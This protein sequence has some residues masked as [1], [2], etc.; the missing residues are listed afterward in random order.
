[1]RPTCSIGAAIPSRTAL[2]RL[3]QG[4]QEPE[5]TNVNRLRS[6]VESGLDFCCSPSFYCTVDRIQPYTSVEFSQS[7]S[8]PHVSACCF[9]LKGQRSEGCFHWLKCAW[10][11]L[12]A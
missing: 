9:I 6:M 4:Q 3:A 1:M 5:N 8:L 11:H 7:L 2:L 12:P 10:G